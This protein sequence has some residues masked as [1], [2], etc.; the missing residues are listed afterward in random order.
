M[1]VAAA[2]LLLAAPGRA[3]DGPPGLDRPLTD[4]PGN[5]A[6]GLK[7]V[8]DAEKGDCTAC[9]SFPVPNMPLDAFGD[10]APPLAGIGTRLTVAQLRQRVADAR[11][12]TPDTIMPAYFSTAG[13]TRVDPKYAGKPILTAQEVE[14]VV[15]YLATLK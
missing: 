13:L 15:S 11:V 3:A 7:L 8:L 6:N 12:V 5:A 1:A 10:L 14:D 4:E 9:H 2:A